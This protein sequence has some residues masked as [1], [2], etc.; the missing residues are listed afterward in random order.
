MPKNND[1]IPS[2]TA[3]TIRYISYLIGCLGVYKMS[4]NKR[5]GLFLCILSLGPYLLSEIVKENHEIEEVKK[6]LES[7]EEDKE[8]SPTATDPSDR[9]NHEIDEGEKMLESSEEDKEINLKAREFFDR[10]KKEDMSISR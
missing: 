1:I 10:R 3:T 9:C 7:S 2:K 8:R 4:G 6:M 5:S